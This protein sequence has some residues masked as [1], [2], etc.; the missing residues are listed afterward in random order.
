MVVITGG[1]GKESAVV[2]RRESGARGAAPALYL[3]ADSS[4]PAL[5]PH[6]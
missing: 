6:V 3:A 4:E 1:P 5:L 2:S